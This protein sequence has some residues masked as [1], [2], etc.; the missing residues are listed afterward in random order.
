MFEIKRTIWSP[1][2]YVVLKHEA[3]MKSTVVEPKILEDKFDDAPLL[4][5]KSGKPDGDDQV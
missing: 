4:S 1:K 5:P 3:G 2:N